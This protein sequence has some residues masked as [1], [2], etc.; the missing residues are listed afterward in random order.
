[1]KLDFF[2]NILSIIVDAYKV[3]IHSIHTMHKYI[4]IQH[5]IIGMDGWMV[6]RRDG[7]MDR[8]EKRIQ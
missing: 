8:M 1:M 4:G 3:F 2:S 7:Q 5:R 6:G